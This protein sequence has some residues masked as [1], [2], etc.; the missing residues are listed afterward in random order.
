MNIEGGT[1]SGATRTESA[2][3]TSG[4]KHIAGPE[5]DELQLMIST[6]YSTHKCLKQQDFNVSVQLCGVTSRFTRQRNRKKK[7]KN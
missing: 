3:I 1:W 7:K 4:S 2:R 5:T 6:T